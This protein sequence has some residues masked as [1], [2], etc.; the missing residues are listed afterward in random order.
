MGRHL[1]GTTPRPAVPAGSHHLGATALGLG[2]SRA[3]VPYPRGHCSPRP[4][5]R[6]GGR[7][8]C[9][10]HRPISIPANPEDPAGAAAAAA[11]RPA[12]RPRPL[13]ER[14]F[15]VGGADACPRPGGAR[16][17]G[18]LM[19]GSA[20]HGAQGLG[21]PSPSGTAPDALSAAEDASRRGTPTDANSPSGRGSLRHATL[22]GRREQDSG[23]EPCTRGPGDAYPVRSRTG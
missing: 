11:A 17:A 3:H 5:D 7:C 15:T 6:R 1:D 23:G 13:A 12:L 4:L 18:A 2:R 20:R 9:P 16:P 10:F 14:S 21:D 22:Y 8:R 19:A